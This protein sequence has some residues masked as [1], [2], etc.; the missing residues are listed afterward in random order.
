V[1]YVAGR[2]RE[3]LYRS[4]SM[5]VMPSL[6]EGFGI[7]ALEAMTL[8]IPVV[9]SNRGALPE[10][11][12]DAGLLVAADDPAGMAAA[13]GRVLGDSALARQ[14]SERGVARARRFTWDASAAAAIDAY[15]LAMERRRSRS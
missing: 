9:V 7:P 1:G 8:G 6:D 11:V 2:D 10:V 4:A 15:R 3:G 13:M 5:I 12:G 14:L